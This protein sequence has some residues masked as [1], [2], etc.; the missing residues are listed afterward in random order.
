MLVTD[1]LCSFNSCQKQHKVPNHYN[2]GVLH[3]SWVK[4]M[5]CNLEAPGLSCTRLFLL[6]KTVK[7]SGLVLVNSRKY[8]NMS[9]CSDM[10][11]KVLKVC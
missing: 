9:C 1:F 8:S 11:E 6:A 2:Q 7:S 10:T 4:C 3:G 5:T